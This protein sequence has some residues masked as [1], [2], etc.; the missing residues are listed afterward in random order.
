[1]VS[2][3][4]P[5]GEDIF[6]FAS[7]SME[8]NLLML[9]F[10]KY[11]NLIEQHTFSEKGRFP[12][13]LVI[14]S[15][16]FYVAYIDY[17]HNVSGPELDIR[18]A[19]FDSDWNTLADIPVTTPAVNKRSDSP[20]VIMHDSLL[21][22]SYVTDWTEE[23]GYY[24]QA[25][26]S[27]YELKKNISSSINDEKVTSGFYLEQNYPNPCTFY[28]TIDFSVP[29]HEMVSL[30]V[31]DIQGREVAVLVNEIKPPGKYSVNFHTKELPDGVYFY[32][33]ITANSGQAR[34]CIVVK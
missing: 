20:W 25:F 16:R 8:G 14:D 15:N 21:Y 6:M 5:K 7:T 22:V 30:K 18:L 28:T 1:M 13:G 26:V 17:T 9:K 32:Q 3:N 29:Y 34:K 11:W 2:I 24:G 4:Q 23:I 12:C 31:F 27:I 33:L 10:D 19:A